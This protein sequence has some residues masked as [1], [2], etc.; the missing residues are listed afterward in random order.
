MK[1]SV[2]LVV[3]LIFTGVLVFAGGSKA[4]KSASGVTALRVGTEGAF[5]PYNFVDASGRADGYDVAVV[6]AVGDLLPEYSFDFVPTAWDGIFVALEAGEFDLIASDI[7]WRQ[8]RDEKYYLSTVPYNWGGTDIIF[9]AD[10]RDIKSLADLKG[11]KVA[12]GIG[13][14]ATLSLEDYVKQHPEEKIEIIYTDGDVNKYLLDVDAGRVDAA[15]S[16]AI[17]AYLAA[18]SLGLKI[19]G[20][21]ITEW[22]V[23]SS[24]LL[25]PRT[26]KGKE[27][28]D[29]IDGALKQLLDNGALSALSKKYFFGK[30]YSTKEA[31]AAN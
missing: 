22:G 18:E 21:T 4:A 10:R 29:R 5:P 31:L 11:K 27:Y 26:A 23:S 25:F 9:K 1:K 24:H 17:T 6:R 14:A 19:N 2:F 15:L 16:S 12:V 20:I 7:S 8:E 13:S 3:L 30:D 28:R